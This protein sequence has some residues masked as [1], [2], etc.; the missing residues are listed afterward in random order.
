M[1]ILRLL[2]V[3]DTTRLLGDKQTLAR[4]E[5]RGNCQLLAENLCKK[6]WEK[7]KLVH[8]N[9]NGSLINHWVR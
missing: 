3:S 9:G 5:A 1:I 4:E 6:R 2:K 8:R 7:H